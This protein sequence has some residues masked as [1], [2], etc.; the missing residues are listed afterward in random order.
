MTVM[1]EKRQT[2]LGDIGGVHPDIADLPASVLDGMGGHEGDLDMAGKTAQEVY[3]NWPD[4][5][6]RNAFLLALSTHIQEQVHHHQAELEAL[7]NQAKANVYG[8]GRRAVVKAYLHDVLNEMVS[9]AEWDERLHPRSNT[10]EFTYSNR[11]HQAALAAAML[12]ANSQMV[13]G[14]QEWE[15][16]IRKRNGDVKTNQPGAGKLPRL[17]V[18]DRVVRARLIKGTPAPLTRVSD[19]MNMAEALGANRAQAGSAGA[20]VDEMARQGAITYGSNSWF[21]RLSSASET[22]D[23]ATSGKG[24]ARL[25]VALAMGKMV[26]KHG[27]EV[28][29]VLGPHMRRYTYKYRG[30]V[31]DPTQVTA[32]ARKRPESNKGEKISNDAYLDQLTLNLAHKREAGGLDAIPTS[33]ENQNML[34]AGATPPSHG[35]LM[36]SKGEVKQQAQGYGDDHYVPFNLKQLHALNGGSYV[37][38]RAFGGPTTE[39]IALAM[40]TGATGFNVIS[41]NGVYKVRFTERT[42]KTGR[43]VGAWAKDTTGNANQLM[44]RRYARLLDAIKNGKVTDPDNEQA[45]TLN[46]RG[47]DL[48]LRSLQKSFPYYIRSVEYI[49][50][51]DGR[52]GNTLEGLRA[53]ESDIDT[54]YIRPYYLKPGTAIAGWHD[55]KLGGPGRSFDEFDTHRLGKARV[56]ATKQKAQQAQAL[57][58]QRLQQQRPVNREMETKGPSDLPQ[59]KRDI[60]GAAGTD[61]GAPVKATPATQ[62][63]GREVWSADRAAKLAGYAKAMFDHLEPDTEDGK[64]I[65]EVLKGEHSTGP[66][67][68]AYDEYLDDLIHDRNGARANLVDEIDG[69]GNRLGDDETGLAIYRHII[70]DEDLF[71]N[72]EDEYETPE[73]IEQTED[74]AYY[75]AAQRYKQ[76]Q[77]NRRDIRRQKNDEDWEWP[78]NDEKGKFMFA[79][80]HEYHPELGGRTLAQEWTL[81]HPDWDGLTRVQAHENRLHAAKQIQQGVDPN[82]IKD[83]HEPPED[84]EPTVRGPHATAEDMDETTRKRRETEDDRQREAEEWARNAQRWD[85]PPF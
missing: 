69:I 17:Q 65:H 26:G 5:T 80:E 62:D 43:K 4:D 15:F 1:V 22:M 85:K 63:A 45:A 2:T 18:G 7:Y 77:A 36:D 47:Y 32:L 52:L 19:T 50:A 70:H 67:G 59:W 57:E 55:P 8:D 46:G 71:G 41:R 78:E 12:H 23:K 3:D 83:L 25:Q 81:P 35:Y 64:K 56:I 53:S 58:T 11:Q 28:S 30:T 72:P 27:P 44:V 61:F 6:W 38:S 79:W 84:Y 49:P 66:A 29:R 14:D 16:T 48:A 60:Y 42:N 33:V 24:G 82:K 76:L 37:R 68:T 13:G 10:G 9:K 34:K 74:H 73:D 20:V 54:G 31:A 75:K 21:D 39:D 40:S 51:G